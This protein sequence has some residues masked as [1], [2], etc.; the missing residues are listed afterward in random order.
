MANSTRWDSDFEMLKAALEV[1]I[2]TWDATFPDHILS[3]LER[4]QVKQLIELLEPI[5]DATKDLQG[6]KYCTIQLVSPYYKLMVS[7]IAN[8]ATIGSV[9]PVQEQLLSMLDHHVKPAACGR[10]M[11]AASFLDPFFRVRVHAHINFFSSCLC[12]ESVFKKTLQKQDRP[13]A[14]LREGELDSAQSEVE[15]LA[16]AFSVAA[17]E[18]EA[19]DTGDEDSTWGPAERSF[20]VAAPVSSILSEISIYAKKVFRP[21]R[22]K[23]GTGRTVTDLIPF[24]H[25]I[26]NEFPL[27]SKFA[28][29]ILSIPATE[30][31]CERVFSV[32][33]RILTRHSYNLSYRVLRA[34]LFI[35][36]NARFARDVN[37][38]LGLRR[39][40]KAYSSTG[41]PV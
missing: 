17:L 14:W 18:D 13:K 6:D 4:Q 30:S 5:R 16:S 39:A 35:Q 34:R 38:S 1:P 19:M 25:S 27:L 41:V 29:S 10:I 37:D 21:A 12:G 26:S 36:Q 8:I 7:Q 23:L 32:A 15:Q 28:M 24:W 22:I 20:T 31:T 40:L 9:V 2:A 11:R 33:G 3:A